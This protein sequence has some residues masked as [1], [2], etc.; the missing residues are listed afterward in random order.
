[1]IWLAWRQFRT[2][3]VLV[4]AILAIIAVALALTGPHLAHLYD[5][6]V[7]TCAAHG[8]CESVRQGFLRQD[9][10][11]QGLSILVVLVPA[12]I[13]MFWGAPLVAREFETGT[14]R[15]AWT[16]SVTRTR[17]LAV[18]LA[19]GGLASMICAGLFSL[20]ITWWSSPFDRLHDS[21]F[22]NFDHRD[23][24]PIGYAAFAFMLGVTLG[25]LI[26]RTVPAMAATLV[27]FVAVRLTFTSYVRTHFMAPLHITSPLELQ[28]SEGINPA[29]WVTSNTTLNAN[30]VAI[31]RYGGIGANGNIQFS[32]TGNDTVKFMGV[33]ECPN[34][35]P[36][37]LHRGNGPSQAVQK[38]FQKCVDHFHLREV[39]TYQPASRYWT[40]Q[41]Y[42]MSIFI[43]LALV[44][45]GVTFWLV[46][47]RI[48]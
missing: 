39:L 1:M 33:G 26:R 15:L 45:A 48:R 4:G 35:I 8:D 46:R 2:Q 13:G 19:L 38:A 3:A 42:E 29:D 9:N 44:L 24:V 21:P 28:G 14:Y 17:W 20:M 18:K 37:Q 22:G 7:A 36:A 10:L 25:V 27:V 40:F 16:Q 34:K 32:A 23:I 31:G 5:T 11:L 12:L 30:G 6:T 47:R 41:W 43:G